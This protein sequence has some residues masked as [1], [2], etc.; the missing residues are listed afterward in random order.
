MSGIKREEIQASFGDNYEG[1]LRGLE[2]RM[3][4]FHPV[5]ESESTRCFELLQRSNQLN[6]SSHR[7]TEEEFSSLLASKDILCY[8]F[9]CYDKFGDYGIAGF[10]S[11]VLETAPRIHD[12]VISCRISQKK[13]ENALMYWISHKLKQDGYNEMFAKLVKTKRNGPLV[14][15]FKGLP[16]DVVME[17][18]KFIVYKLRDMGM[19]KDEKIITTVFRD[20]V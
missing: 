8:A 19:V 10:I 12:L 20:R 1:F 16:F 6:I 13:F 7:Y 11:I 2:M 3:E 9:R 18:E 14:E 17:D 15:L 5:E 4:I